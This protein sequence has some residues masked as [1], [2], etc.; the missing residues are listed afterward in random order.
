[1]LALIVALV[2]NVAVAALPVQ[3]PEEPVQ[4]PVTLPVTSPVTSAV[5]T[6]RE[7]TSLVEAF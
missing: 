7:V 5:A 6:P 4:L 2:A 3:D 1:M